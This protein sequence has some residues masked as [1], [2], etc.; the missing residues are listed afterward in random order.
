MTLE[1]HQVTKKYGE[2]TV[3]R[4][5]DLIVR[6]GELLA[7]VGPSGS[8]KTTLLQIMGTLDKPTGGTVSLAGQEV[9]SMPD[10]RLAEIRARHIGF[11]F[12]QFFLNPMLSAVDNV[13]TGLLYTGMPRPER[14]ERAAKALAQ[15]GMSHR[16]K[17]RPGQL[18]GGE[19][20]RVAIAR[21]VVGRPDVVLADEPTGNLDSQS[22]AA[23]AGLLRELNESGTT[24]VVITHDDR[25]A[26]TMP[27]MVR[28]ED[29]EI[30]HD[31]QAPTGAVRTGRIQDE[32]IAA[33]IE[34]GEIIHDGQPLAGSPRPRPSQSEPIVR[35]DRPFAGM[36]HAAQTREEPASC[37]PAA[38]NAIAPSPSPKGVIP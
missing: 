26:A 6:P 27:R 28:I 37:D 36:S 7:I 3:L 30:I 10:E 15:V 20:Q 4:K 17:H 5:I 29:G 33:R 14:R 18:S 35:E 12:Q 22:G 24:V 1:L 19:C 38:I 25:L 34:G 31:N 2:L 9:T 16:T 21:A 11:V 13:A 23:V 8:G 32:P